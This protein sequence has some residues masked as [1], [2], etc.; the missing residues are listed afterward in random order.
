MGDQ[1]EAVPGKVGGTV[2]V[3]AARASIS[4]STANEGSAH[5]TRW[6]FRQVV[7]STIYPGAITVRKECPCSYRH[8]MSSR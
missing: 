7:Q 8:A 4:R 5:A 2:T 6:R 1:E 3:K